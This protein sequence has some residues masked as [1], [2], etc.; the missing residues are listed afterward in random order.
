VDGARRFGRQNSP[1]GST[2]DTFEEYFDTYGQVVW[3]KDAEGYLTYTAYDNAKGGVT[4]SVVDANPSS[5]SSPPVTAPTRGSGLPTALHLATA[6]EVDD[7]GRTTKV[8]DPRG[9]VTYTVYKDVDHEVRTYPGW[10]GTSATTGPTVVSREDRSR[11]YR[12]SLTMSASPS[13]S[14]A[15][16]TGTESIASIQSLSR[17]VLDNSGRLIHVDR[18][19]D[20]TAGSPTYSASSVTIGTLNTNYYRTSYEYD[21]G[22]RKSKAVNALGTITRI[23]YDGIGRVTS[24]WIGTDDTPTTGYFSPTNTSGTNL[25]KISENEYDGGGVGDGTL[26]KVTTF[27]DGSSSVTRVTRMYYDWRDRQIA[28]KAGWSSSNDNTGDGINRQLTFCDLDN[29]GRCIVRYIYDGDGVGVGVSS[30]VITSPSSSALRAKTEVQYDEQGRV[31]QTIDYAVDPSNGTASSSIKLVSNNWYDRRGNLIKSSRPGGLASKSVYDGAGRVT[32]NYLS[33]GGGDA[34]AGSSNNWSDADDVSGDKVLEQTEYAYNANDAVILTVSKARNHDETATGAL[35]SQGTSPKARVSYI[36]AFYDA[37]DRL[38]ASVAYGTNGGISVSAPSDSPAAILPTRSDTVLV[39]NYT[40]TTAGDLDEVVDPKAIVAKT[41]YD[42]L[43]R[44]TKVVEN[45]TDGTPTASSNRTTLYTYDGMNHIRTLTADMPTGTN[46]QTTEYVYGVTT[47][48]GS[49]INSNSLL[50]TVKYPG[51]S[52]GAASGNS[53]EQNSYTYNAVGELKTKVDQNGTIHTFSRDILGRMKVDAVSVATGNPQ[54][55][56][57]SVLRQEMSYNTQGSVHQLTAYTAAAGGTV[58]N[59]IQ[60]AYNNFGQLTTEYQEHA[61]A[62]NTSTSPKVQYAY[63]ETSSG[64]ANNSR[65]T[66]VTYPNGRI[67][68]YEYSSGLDNDVGRLTYLAD[69]SSGSVGPHLEEYSYFGLGGTAKRAH[70]QPAVDLTYVKQ[71]G[72]SVADAGDQYTGLD[73]FGRVVDQRWLVTS[74]GSHTDR[75]QYG[76]DRNSNRL[77]KDNK[78]AGDQSELYHANG[79]NGYD[80]LNRLTDFRRGTLSASGSVLDTVSTAGKSRS[81]SLDALGNMAGVTTDGASESRTH[82]SGNQVTA[83]GGTSLTYDNNGSLTNDGTQSYVY[84]AWNMLV[85]VKNAAGSSTIVTYAY[86]AASRRISESPTGGTASDQYYSAGWQVLEEREG[87]TAKRQY[88]WSPVYVDALILRDR[89]ADND[90]SHTL[91]ER[92]YAQQDA[93][94]NVTAVMN[95]SGTVQERYLYDPYGARSFFDASY[96]SRGSS[97]YG[98]SHGHQ[99][100][101]HDVE[102]GLVG[103][104]NR[105][106]HVG[107]GKWIQSDPLGYVDGLSLNAFVAANPINY[108]DPKGTDRYRPDNLYPYPHHVALAVDNWKCDKGKWVKTGVLVFDFA[109]PEGPFFLWWLTS[110]ILARGQ[111]SMRSESATVPIGSALASPGGASVSVVTIRSNPWEDLWLIRILQSEVATPPPFSGLLYNC[112]W[113]VWAHINV[114]LGVDSRGVGKTNCDACSAADEAPSPPPPPIQV[115]GVDMPEGM[116]FSSSMYRTMMMRE[117][118][119]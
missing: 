52:T 20:L 55:V 101:K 91:E 23:I 63:T 22:G 67:V 18:Y 45:Y 58:V 53:S 28:T 92:L 78:V 17:Q 106:L 90:G 35:N 83:N 75:F 15:K 6:Y 68:R 72:E 48:N 80:G 13:V 98:W 42:L 60:R 5:I 104:R 21:D 119:Y 77:Y 94:F 112:Q 33:D 99:G 59:Q 105:V 74:S 34:T 64:A 115:Y 111:V 51:K 65:L 14:S 73:R 79:S 84:D 39:T 114:G 56:D 86:D 4:L 66:K 110:P 30:G 32:V 81:W 12:E 27:L 87:G 76:H 61:G 82:N 36:T 2:A 44:V 19:F 116:D 46:D 41:Y 89:D 88:V 113:W 31:Y 47:G 107:F 1:G 49:D 108:T 8:T 40:Y 69:D 3:T 25:V 24:T 37:A 96:A 71:S 29:I 57:T 95:A 11:N 100:L 102:T 7:L 70:P 85:A 10:D 9:N 118:V 103:V 50:A 54:N 117:P 109:A 62:V 93:N 16:P 26:T 43:G 97:S 38:R